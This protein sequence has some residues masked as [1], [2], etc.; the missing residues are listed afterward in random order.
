[1]SVTKKGNINGYNN[2]WY[3]PDGIKYL[4]L[5]QIHEEVQV[6]YDIECDNSFVSSKQNGNIYLDLLRK[7]YTNW[8]WH[9]S[10]GTFYGHKVDSNKSK[11]SVRQSSCSKKAC[12]HQDIIGRPITEYFIIYFEEIWLKS[13]KSTQLK[14]QASKSSR[15]KWRNCFP[16]LNRNIHLNKAHMML[17]IVQ[18]QKTLS[19]TII[20][21]R[22]DDIQYV[23]QECGEM[24]I[25]KWNIWPSAGQ[26]L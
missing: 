15:S 1:M 23:Q 24:M 5:K 14:T 25:H 13:S 19:I 12:Q 16:D 11:Y 6:T 26:C 8:M 10:I 7:G 3:H 2:L 22:A 9:T 17:L 4:V 18:K 21:H 20:L